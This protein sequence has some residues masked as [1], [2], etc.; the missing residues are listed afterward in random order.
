MDLLEN[1]ALAAALEF[2]GDESF[3]FVASVNRRFR[4]AYVKICLKNG[5]RTSWKAGVASIPCARIMIQNY[6]R[7][8]PK[9]WIKQ[10]NCFGARMGR[11][12]G[13]RF[14]DPSSSKIQIWDLT[15]T[16]VE[17]AASNG[18]IHVFEMDTR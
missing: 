6:Q 14:L 4:K 12:D 15:R 8:P 17:A 3:L 16:I 11:L 13:I 2:V 1:D 18:H 9:D 5:R 7:D 10:S